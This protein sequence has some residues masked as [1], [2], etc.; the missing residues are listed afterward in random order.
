MAKDT[1]KRRKL[2]DGLVSGSVLA[3]A[4]GIVCVYQHHAHAH[5]RGE[6]HGVT[7]VIGEHQERATVGNESAMQSDPVHH[8][9]HAELAHP[10]V[11]IIA[12][13]VLSRD[14]ARALEQR[15]VRAG[16]IGRAAEDLRQRRPDYVEHRL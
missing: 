3:E 8:R 16:Q 11:K 9:C 12:A 4:D 5:E 10:V 6:T 2:L 15:V 1:K 14:G 13:G 7:C